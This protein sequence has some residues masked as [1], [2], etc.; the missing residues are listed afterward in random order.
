M[1]VRR[2]SGDGGGAETRVTLSPSYATPVQM[3]V[4]HEKAE[5]AFGF[6][7]VDVDGEPQTGSARGGALM[8]S[9]MTA[10]KS[11]IGEISMLG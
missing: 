9:A 11:R 4:T 7:S 2:L 5:N 10:S 6:Y 1:D 3:V 8:T